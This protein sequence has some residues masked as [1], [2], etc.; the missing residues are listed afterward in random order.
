MTAEN[1]REALIIR[2]ARSKSLKH[3]LTRGCPAP[4]RRR[5]GSARA[6]G[7]GSRGTSPARR[8]RRRRG[9]GRAPA[10]PGR[11]G[12][13]CAQGC[14]GSR[15]SPSRG[16]RRL[17]RRQRE[18]RRRRA[19]RASALAQR[20]RRSQSARPAT[21]KASA[22]RRDAETAMDEYDSAA[23]VRSTWCL[24]KYCLGGPPAQR[25]R[26]LVSWVASSE[27]HA[28]RSQVRR[29]CLRRRRLA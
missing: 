7:G 24:P 1:H 9:R 8:R 14:A 4:T 19:G 20:D 11:R 5:F 25:V 28:L 16:R 3:T 26:S 18:R 10:A 13:G 2:R 22:N 29:Q 27:V 12:A 17:L 15:G 6:S 21:T 23:A